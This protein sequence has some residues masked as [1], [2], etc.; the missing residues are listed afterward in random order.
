M[1]RLA[2]L[3][4]VLCLASCAPALASTRAPV[5][6]APVA[7][8]SHGTDQARLGFG[9]R[10]R[11]GGS[12]YRYPSRYRYGYG[13]RGGGFWRG[14]FH[15][16]FWSWMFS[17]LFGYGFGFGIPFFPILLLMLVALVLMR[18]RRRDVYGSPYG[19]W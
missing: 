1:S 18:R 4:A 8:L 14:F 7:A 10:S 3:T 9:S 5:L 13:R 19:R 12:R 11:F 16:V 2:L 17:H 6:T 15:G